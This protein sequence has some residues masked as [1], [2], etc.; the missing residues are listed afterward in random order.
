MWLIPSAVRNTYTL[1]DYGDWV[2]ST[3]DRSSPFVQLLP[4]TNVTAAHTDF[5]NVRLGGVDTTGQPQWDLLPVSQ[6]Q[7]SP[8]SAKEKE[9]MYQEMILSRWPE[10]FVGC[11][12]LASLLVGCCIWRCCCRNRCAKNRKRKLAAAVEEQDSAMP[13]KG[14]ESIY[15]V[16]EEQRGRKDTYQDGQYYR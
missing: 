14:D 11:L 10:I 8:I 16:L 12:A 7:H 3:N 6:M 2:D 9:E 5:V 4:I 15:V 13:M 1:L